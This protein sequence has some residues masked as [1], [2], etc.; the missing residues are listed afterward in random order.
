MDIKVHRK[1]INIPTVYSQY[2]E[3]DSLW[4]IALS[5]FSQTTSSIF[6]E[7]MI[8]ILEKNPTGL[9]LD[10][11]DNGG[12][13]LGVWVDILSV[14]FE[15]ETPVVSIQGSNETTSFSTKDL[16]NFY[17]GKLVVLINEN[18]ASASEIVA[19][20]IQDYERAAIVGTQSYGK[21]SVQELIV[22]RDGSELKITTSH[23]FTPKLQKIEK[24]GIIPDYVIELEPDDYENEYDRQLEFAKSLLK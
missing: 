10:L 16:G 8:G 13:L 2:F 3:E 4:Y 14:F 1:K 9:I 22:L 20:A 17:A 21:G 7:E 18:S 11:R 12:W 24:N 5:S 15:K 19:W 6:L 23:W